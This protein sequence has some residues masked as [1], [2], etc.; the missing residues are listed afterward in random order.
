MEFRGE[1]LVRSMG[2]LIR[3]LALF[4]GDT[5]VVLIVVLNRALLAAADDD[6]T[7]GKCKREDLV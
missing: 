7:S 3:V 5:R 6:S 1:V 2:R 4:V